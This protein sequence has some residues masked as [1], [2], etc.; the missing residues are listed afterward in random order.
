MSTFARTSVARLTLFSL[1]LCIAPLHAA[2]AAR[3]EGRL[4]GID[5]LP[6]SG[7]RLHLIDGAGRDVARSET[8]SAGVYTFRDLRPGEYGLGIEDPSGRVAPVAAPAVRVAG[9]ELARRDLKLARADAATREAALGANYGMGIWWAGLSVAAK[10]WV[11]VAIVV[12]AGLTYAALD[13][14]DEPTA[15]PTD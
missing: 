1:V 15:S 9:G 11:V 14:D 13:D 8:D 12:A 10:T 6:A 5:G 3:I 2:P 4:L 7:M